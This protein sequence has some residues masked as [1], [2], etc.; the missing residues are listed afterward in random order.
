MKSAISAFWTS[1]GCSGPTF[2]NINRRQMH[3]YWGR[4]ER[5]PARKHVVWTRSAWT[6]A[7]IKEQWYYG[8]VAGSLQGCKSWEESADAHSKSF[9]VH[10]VLSINKDLLAG[11]LMAWWGRSPAVCSPGCVAIFQKETDIASACTVNNLQTLNHLEQRLLWTFLAAQ[12]SNKLMQLCQEDSRSRLDIHSTQVSSW[13]QR[14]Y[15]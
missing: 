9:L 11:L 8:Q 5:C 15:V 14:T 4:Q 10:L 2:W 3:W 6:W 13:Y 1:C 12:M 7:Q